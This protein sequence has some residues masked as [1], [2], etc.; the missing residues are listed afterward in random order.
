[1][2]KYMRIISIIL[3]MILCCSCSAKSAIDEI[4]ASTDNQA[5][6][7]DSIDLG[8][9]I[10]Q[11]KEEQTQTPSPSP[12][13][14]PVEE[15]VVVNQDDIVFP[16]HEQ[17]ITDD[18]QT[19]PQGKDLQLVFLGDS[20]FDNNRDGTGVPYL[21]AVQCNADVY[22]LAI[23]G[24]TATI[25]LTESAENE[26]WESRGLMGIVKAM[27]KQIPTDIFE[28]TRAKE[29]LDNPNVDFSKTD[30]FIIEYGINDYFEGAPRSYDNET[31]NLHTY[32]GALRVA[33]QQLRDLAPGATIIL[34]PPHYCL[35]YNGDK[36]VG[37]S[38][39]TDKGAGTL[40]D[41][42]GTCEYID[43]EQQTLFLNTYYDLGIDSY[44][45]DKYLEDGIHLTQEGRQ[46]Y[47]DAL[48]RLILAHEEEKNN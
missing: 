24:T 17:V 5:K 45:A 20:I 30:Y 7:E 42:M 47:A 12:S 10:K 40:R 31:H 2:K 36:Y 26:K 34:C 38:N 3:V 15:T 32:V 29:I 16:E 37:D 39:V 48:A 35:F 23:G 27:T 11:M 19:E 13:P 43:G 28:G 44:T 14:S 1:M 9:V 8:E 33:I 21:T 22:N 46:I 18:D 6:N 25:K 41:Y 4:G